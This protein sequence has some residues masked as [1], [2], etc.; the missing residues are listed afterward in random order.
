MNQTEQQFFTDLEKK[1]WTA[2]D[3]LRSSLDASVYKFCYLAPAGTLDRYG[4][5]ANCAT[6][7]FPNSSPAN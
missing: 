1:L 7:F 4:L 6:P 3:K 5:S 2:A